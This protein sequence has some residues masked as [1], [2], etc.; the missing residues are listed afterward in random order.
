MLFFVSGSWLCIAYTSLSLPLKLAASALIGFYGLKVLREGV[1]LQHPQAIVEVL[2]ASDG[3]WQIKDRSGVTTV[4]QVCGDS[5]LMS[6]LC[7]LRFKV[8]RGAKRCVLVFR[9]QVGLSAYTRLLMLLRT[10]KVNENQCP[11]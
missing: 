5:T 1:L 4:A 6:F 7:I 3:S 9:H 8:P 11:N 10:S 2:S